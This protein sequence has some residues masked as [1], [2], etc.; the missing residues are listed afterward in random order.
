VR[1]LAQYNASTNVTAIA[2]EKFFDA[3]GNLKSETN[4]SVDTAFGY[5]GRY[6]DDD[7]GLQWNLNRWGN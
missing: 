6:F 3:F 1:H 7:T 5:T 4:P 2:N